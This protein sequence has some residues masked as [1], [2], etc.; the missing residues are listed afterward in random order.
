MTA[1]S[2]LTFVVPDDFDSI[3]PDLA[4]LEKRPMFKI[5]GA[6]GTVQG[7]GQLEAG[8]NVSI[9]YHIQSAKA[10]RV[11]NAVIGDIFSRIGSG[12]DSVV[13]PLTPA[14]LALSPYNPDL[15]PVVTATYL[16][17]ASR[18]D[19]NREIIANSFPKDVITEAGAIPVEEPSVPTI[20]KP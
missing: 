9:S 16:Q 2:V 4:Y 7:L 1:K 20:F 5:E 8:T 18:I 11:D 6:D 12:F 15:P 3:A 17:F 10:H 14:E 13:V 19:R